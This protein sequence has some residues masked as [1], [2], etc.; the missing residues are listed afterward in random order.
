MNFEDTQERI[1]NAGEY[2]LGTLSPADKR[3]FEARMAQDLDLQAE[4]YAWQDQLLSL[5]QRVSPMAVRPELWDQLMSRLGV[6]A[7]VPPVAQAMAVTP[8]A[9]EPVWRS[10]GFW[11][12][13]SAFALAA[14][15]VMGT[16]LLTQGARDG[17]A[18]T[19]VAGAQAARYLAVLQSPDK[20]TGWVVEV[21]AGD[22]VRLVPV[23]ETPPVP[24][25]KTLQF[26]TK[27]DGAKGP[28]SLGLVKAGQTYVVPVSRLPGLGSKQ[29]FELTLEP[30]GGSTIGRP[31]GPVLFVGRTVQ[32]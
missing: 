18:P 5:N 22:A 30:A 1:A 14:S 12:A 21:V 6:S 2:V 3:T 11:R 10:V 13:T 27:P 4:V 7:V 19:G 15:V 29:L 20:A 28:T 9:N 23:G 24:E 17:A 31:T 16:V 32:L 25:G 26:W 8:A